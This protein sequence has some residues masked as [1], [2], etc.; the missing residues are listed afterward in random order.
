MPKYSNPTG[1]SCS[2]CHKSQREVDKI[3]AGP[4]VYICSECIRLCLDIIRENAATK[5]VSWGNN[6][7][8]SPAKIKAY[9]DQYVVGQDLAKRK[10]AV[11]V[12]NHYKRL[13][14]HANATE[15]DVEV[16]KSNVLLIGPTGT[17]KTLIAR[18]LARFLDVPFVIADATTLTEAGYVGEDVENIVLNLY[19]AAN[20]NLERAQR[21]IVYIDEIDKLS[22]KAFT[23]SVSRDVSGEGVQQAL[24]K[25]LEGTLANIQVKGNKRLP[26]QEHVPI[27]TTNILFIV[28]GSFEGLD[29][30]IETR[31]GKRSVGFHR[32]SGGADAALPDEKLEQRRNLLRQVQTED[33]ERF[34][35]IPEFIGR[36]PV[37][38]VMDPL[39]VDDL[40]HVMTEPKNALVKQYQKLLKFEKVK[41]RFTDEAIRAVA[42]RAHDR[43]SGARGLRA[44]LEQ[45]MLDVMYEVPSVEGLSE[46]VI[47]ENVV[48]GKGMPQLQTVR[49]VG[50]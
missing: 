43:K 31:V 50:A 44:I 27:D 17:G 11:A 25:I 34:G 1:L 6:G 38:A 2:F 4:N 24:L 8:P 42:E 26:N 48:A 5:P 21:G 41:L 20:N 9:L 15:K 29:R 28:G 30:T 45:V 33:L 10:L 23:S 32:D 12:Y 13:E 19:Q 14:A 7:V 22:K 36:L 16:Q 39:T 46:V 37:V 35:L 49:D 18:T 40:I 3:I 47:D